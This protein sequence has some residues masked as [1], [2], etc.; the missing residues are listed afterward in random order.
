MSLQFN[1][2][3]LLKKFLIL[4]KFD[5]LFSFLSSLATTCHR[6]FLMLSDNKFLCDGKFHHQCRLKMNL[7]YLRIF[8]LD[9]HFNIDGI[10]YWEKKIKFC[11]LQACFLTLKQ[12]YFCRTTTSSC[13]V[14]FIF[15]IQFSKSSLDVL[16]KIMW[17]FLWSSLRE[18]FWQHEH[19]L[20]L[21]YAYSELMNCA[22]S[23]FAIHNVMKYGCY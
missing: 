23:Y 7:K 1:V 12:C 2:I 20:Q 21:S 14:S 17:P 13:I 4:A 8:S 11:I 16:R 3:I 9:S 22:S 5:L 18:H 15:K 6:I 19:F 10:S